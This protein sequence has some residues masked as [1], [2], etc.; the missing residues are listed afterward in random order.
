[1]GEFVIPSTARRALAL[2]GVIGLS[3]CSVLLV[4]PNAQAT[5]A[6]TATSAADVFHVSY[7][8]TDAPVSETLA[9][10]GS[11]SAQ[12]S[13]DSVGNSTAQAAA[14]YPGDTVATLPGTARGLLP[15]AAP[16]PDVPFIARSR[17]PGAQSS[18]QTVGPYVLTATSKEQGSAATAGGDSLSQSGVTIGKAAARA[19]AGTD[20]GRVTASA[21]NEVSGISGLAVDVGGVRSLAKIVYDGSTY[22]PTSEFAVTGFSVAGVALEVGPDGL[23][24]AGQKV[25]LPDTSPVRKILADQGFEVRYLVPRVTKTSVLTAG[26]EIDKNVEPPAGA[27][28]GTIKQSLIFGRSFVAIDNASSFD[29]TVPP[30]TTP[31]S[32]PPSSGTGTTG[33]GSGNGVAPPPD[34]SPRSVGGPTSGGPVEP[35][36]APPAVQDSSP[37]LTASS[38]TPRSLDLYPPFVIGAIA[39]LMIS[40]VSRMQGVRHP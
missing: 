24:L 13:L 32:G 17:Y 21:S 10:D 28:V 18:E 11:P 8:V 2:A 33:S 6:F 16:I 29:D 5:I 4:A 26:L 39:L 31:D 15:V 25:P 30:V 22:T 3:T 19:D 37:A 9:D 12:A 20:R 14:V 1:V 34:V 7:F 27:P 35:N 36:V 38:G 40:Q 23:S